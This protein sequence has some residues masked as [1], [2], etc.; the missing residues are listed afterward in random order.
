MLSAGDDRIWRLELPPRNIYV[1]ASLKN[2]VEALR[3]AIQLQDAGFC[4]TS[5]WLRNDFSKKPI[6]PDGP[7]PEQESAWRMWATY[8]EAWGRRDVEDLEKSDTLIILASQPSSSGG[9]HFELG[10]FVGAG[11]KNIITVGD[12]PNVFFWHESVRFIKTMDGLIEWLQDSSHG[13][14][15]LPP[16]EISQEPVDLFAG[17]GDEADSPF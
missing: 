5:R 13:T 16:L 8:E 4:V 11:K 9:F 2:Q 14:T 3:F 1:A 17:P 15:T 6:V 7:G 12:R 10:H